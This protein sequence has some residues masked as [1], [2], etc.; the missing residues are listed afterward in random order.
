ML[1][2]VPYSII[3]RDPCSLHIQSSTPVSIL[4]ILYV[5]ILNCLE[6]RGTLVTWGAFTI[7]ILQIIVKI[8]SGKNHQWIQNLGGGWDFFL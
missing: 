3:L 2:S 5:V 6:C 1:V 4:G 8:G 7:I